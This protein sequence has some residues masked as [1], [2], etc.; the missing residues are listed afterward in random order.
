[1]IKVKSK[2]LTSLL[3]IC[4]I[5]LFA[6]DKEMS[7]H[8]SFNSSPLSAENQMK[9][10]K[11]LNDK[12]AREENIS[13]MAI[14][15]DSQQFPA[16]TALPHFDETLADHQ[17]K[18]FPQNN[19]IEL[20]DGSEW[21]VDSEDYYRVRRWVEGNIVVIIPTDDRENN[22]FK[23]HN[24]NLGHTVSVRPFTG[25]TAHGPNTNWIVGLDHQVGHVY[26]VDGKG[27]RMTW[28]IDKTFLPMF[29]E[30][31]VDHTVII[32]N[33]DKN[34]AE[35]NISW[36]FPAYDYVLINVNKFNFIPSKPL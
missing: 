24:K 12:Q 22:P 32:A 7:E 28:A 16:V 19:I 33:Y 6:N 36:L 5:S 8:V 1:M 14:P 23:M 21:T 15:I 10:E 13:A 20:T 18:S 30:W 27:H 17:I 35:R 29:E 34:W 26:V 9:M 11:I 2:T 25:P 31:K 4:C 3:T